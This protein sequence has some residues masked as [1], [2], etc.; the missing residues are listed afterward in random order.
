[1]ATTQAS[2]NP[3][4]AFEHK[5][6][7]YTSSV[8]LL[9]LLSNS[10]FPMVLQFV[11]IALNCHDLLVLFDFDFVGFESERDLTCLDLISSFVAVMG[12]LVGFGWVI[13]V[14][15]VR[16]LKC[17]GSGFGLFFLLSF[18]LGVYVGRFGRVTTWIKIKFWFSDRLCNPSKL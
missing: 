5:R 14:W 15:I 6:Y 1:M 16:N 2:L 13:L 9:L 3:L 18:E 4:V 7:A 17:L 8:L 10:H 12:N 11:W